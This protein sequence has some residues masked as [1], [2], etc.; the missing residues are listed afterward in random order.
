[1][2]KVAAALSPSQLSRRDLLIAGTILGAEAIAFARRPWKQV[3]AVQSGK[4]ADIVPRQ[5]DGWA[6]SGSTGLVLPPEQQKRSE[7]VYTDTLARNYVDGADALVMLLIA[8]DPTQSGMLQ[9]HRPEACYPASGFQTTGTQPVNIPLGS[10]VVVP[11]LFMTATNGPRVEQ[12]LYWTRIGYSF[13][14]SYDDQRSALMRQNLRGLEPDGA[15]IRMSVIDPDPARAVTRLKAFAVS[16][17]AASGKQSRAL[18][19]GPPA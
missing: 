2:N 9:V 5:F 11:A 7:R 17:F 8:Y 18:L 14:L 10:E 4:L 6:D 3:V 12:I 19:I 1:M 13:P 16:L 15:L